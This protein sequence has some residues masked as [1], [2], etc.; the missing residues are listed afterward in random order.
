MKT[1]IINEFGIDRLTI[2]EQPVP[3]PKIGEV[4]VRIRAASINYRDLRV[5]N[6]T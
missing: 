6:G 3:E 2:E 1:S 5:V 4:L